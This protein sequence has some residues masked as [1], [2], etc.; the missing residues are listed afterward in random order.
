M[1][2]LLILYTTQPSVSRLPRVCPTANGLHRDPRLRL[3]PA[4]RRSHTERCITAL[5]PHCKRSAIW[6]HYRC[7]MWLVVRRYHIVVYH[8]LLLDV[9]GGGYVASFKSRMRSY[10]L[11]ICRSQVYPGLA[12]CGGNAVLKTVGSHSWPVT[13]SSSRNAFTIY[14][15]APG[16]SQTCCGSL[17]GLQ[18]NAYCAC[19]FGILEFRMWCP[20]PVVVLRLVI[21]VDTSRYCPTISLFHYLLD[22]NTPSNPPIRHH[23]PPTTT[24][25]RKTPTIPIGI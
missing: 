1:H 10:V 22:I 5:S 16:S 14:S 2:L 21:L 9:L 20:E 25:T 17:A 23:I 8:S 6:P 3:S 11:G 24:P 15:C 7:L 19:A 12:R 18:S 13:S 4:G